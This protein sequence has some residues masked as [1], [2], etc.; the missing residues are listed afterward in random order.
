MAYKNTSYKTVKRCISCNTIISEDKDTCYNP[1]CNPAIKYYINKFGIEKTM[2][3]LSNN[4]WQAGE[5]ERDI[6]YLKKEG[7]T[8]KSL[9]YTL[10]ALRITQPIGIHPN[11]IKFVNYTYE[12]KE[13]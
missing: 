9:G 7:Y 12:K 10:K 13:S 11:T 8:L 1:K 4:I 6:K 2:I 5:V 3:F